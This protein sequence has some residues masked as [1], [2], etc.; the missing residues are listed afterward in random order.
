MITYFISIAI[1]IIGY[2]VYGKYLDRM[3]GSD[4]KRVTPAMFHPDGVDTVPLPTWRVF[5][6]QFLNIAGL[7]PIFGAIMG[8]MY[9]PVVFLWITFGTI[10]AG[11]VHDFL[12]AMLSLRLGGDSLPEIVG[13]FLGKGIRFF[14][15]SFTVVLMVLV[16]TVFLSGPA[17]ILGNLT[18]GFMSVKWWLIIIFSYYILATLFPIDKIIGK[19]YPFFGMAMLFMEACILVCVWSHLSVLPELNSETFRNLH[20]Q[21]DKLYLFPMLFITV[22]CGAISGFHATQSPLMAR[23]IKTEKDGRKVFYGSMVLEGFVAI[24]WSAAAIA[25]FGGVDGFHEFM[26]G[27]GSQAAVAV[28]TIANGWLGVAGGALALIGVVAAP[29]TSADTAFRSG[30]LILA[31]FLHMDQ[32]SLWKRLMLSLPMFAITAILLQINFDIIWRYF[33]WS[34]QLLAMITLWAITV[35]L[36]NVK[37]NY[38][39]ALLPSMFM[40][41][42]CTTYILTAPEGFQVPYHASCVA[43]VV[44]AIVLGMWFFIQTKNH[45]IFTRRG[46]I[47]G[48]P[49]RTA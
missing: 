2:L 21:A 33:A 23:C 44:V 29:I 16:G 8:V 10:F 17:S 37:K 24:N 14:M 31:D 42:V 18:V 45:Y 32:R 11:A 34:N 40:T 27:H 6:I 7:G 9:G 3:F 30:R 36:K 22:A 43:G 49:R 28:T 13:L 41:A 20:P 15:R 48:K 5:L 1:L 26:A 46:I 35:Y 25:F 19:I 39:V 38:F 12:S 47:K 4:A